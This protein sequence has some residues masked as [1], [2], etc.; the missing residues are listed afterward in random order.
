MKK[1]EA[2]VRH[3]KLEDVK[4]A[5]NELGLQGMTITEVRGF[6]RQKG[7]TEMYRGTEYEV[8][9][10]PKIKIEIIVPS[11]NCQNVVDTIVRA[12][13]TGQ[14]GDGKIFITDLADA[15]RI[16]TGESGRDAL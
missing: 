10:V 9:F 2:I 4:N 14:V 16:R 5:L 6:G 1:I 12:A 8:D 13:G 3:Y 11:E 7:H 15:V